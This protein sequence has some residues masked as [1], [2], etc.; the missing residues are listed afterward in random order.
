MFMLESNRWLGGTE[1]SLKDP[2]LDI[3]GEPS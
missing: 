2:H 1:D 3:L